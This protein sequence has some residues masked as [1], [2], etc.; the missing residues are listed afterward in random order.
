MY[1]TLGGNGVNVRDRCNLSRADCR[2]KIYNDTF[3]D[4]TICREKILL[5]AEKCVHHRIK[6]VSR[7][8][9][10]TVYGAFI[11]TRGIFRIS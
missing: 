3:T 5:T 1:N 6:N 8:Y 9:K 11:I 2:V 10:T 4:V 7:Y